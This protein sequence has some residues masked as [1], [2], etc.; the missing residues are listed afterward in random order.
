MAG[1]YPTYAGPYQDRTGPRWGRR[2]LVTAIVLLVVVIGP[3]LVADRVAAGYAERVLADR[4]AQ[5]IA[6]QQIESSHPEVEV[7]GFPFLTQ[8]L[9]G[10]YESISILLRDVQAAVGNDRVHLSELAID[11][12]GVVASIDTLRSGQGEVIAESVEGNGILAYDSVAQLMNRPGLRLTE[13]KGKLI[14][15]AP[16]EVLGQEF[17]LNGTANLTVDDGVVQVRF[18]ELTAEGLPSSP[19]ARSL[20]DGYAKQISVDIP[21]PELPFQ[22]DVQQ[23][24]ALP[25]GLAV[26]V[27]AED[28]PL[29]AL[30]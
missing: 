24:Q 29:N 11:A 30:A 2:L 25:Q 10:R 9:A 7:A 19:R 3:L 4:F 6:G 22:L 26:T 14:V 18:D 12:R 5:Q 28:V 20:V 21:L 23:V 27:R 1:D 13:Q 15:T 16:V 17:T 8:V